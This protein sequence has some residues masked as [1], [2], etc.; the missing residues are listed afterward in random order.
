MRIVGDVL[1]AHLWG[2]R[3]FESF[4]QGQVFAEKQNKLKSVWGIP[5]QTETLQGCT[6]NLNDCKPQR[7]AWVFLSSRRT[8]SG[9]DRGIR[10]HG[11]LPDSPT[12]TGHDAGA[13]AAIARLPEKAGVKQDAGLGRGRQNLD[14]TTG[15]RGT[16]QQEQKV[17][18]KP[19]RHELQMSDRQRYPSC[20]LTHPPWC[21]KHPPR[22]YKHPPNRG[23][24]GVKELQQ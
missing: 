22:C 23:L 6:D 10:A 8:S 12:S 9:Q 3:L 16:T 18:L 1:R 20:R 11:V 4:L 19:G 7:A 5:E 13:G 14:G 24:P 21:Y 15:S 17:T 2:L